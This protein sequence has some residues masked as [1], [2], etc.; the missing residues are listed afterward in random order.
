MSSFCADNA[1]VNFGRP[2]QVDNARHN[3]VF[4]KL[5]ERSQKL[6]PLGCPSHILHNAAKRSSERLPI[7]I[8]SIAFKLASHFK[9]STLRHERLKDLCEQLETDY[10]TLP[11]HGPTRWTTL[12]K[13]VDR[14]LTLWEPLKEFFSSDKSPRML[15]QFFKDDGNRIICLFL[16]SALKS[17]QGPIMLLQ[18]TSLLF[19]ELLEIMAGFRK[20]M[21]DRL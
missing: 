19:P 14:I 4:K 12:L 16:Q 11:T 7:D 9:G 15:E 21:S 8:E 5:K 6:I 10:S 2:G 1:P 18:K 20:Q 13:V 17:F 3:N